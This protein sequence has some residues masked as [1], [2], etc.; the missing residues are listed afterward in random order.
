M[1]RKEEFKKDIEDKDKEIRALDI[2][3]KSAYSKQNEFTEKVLRATE[4]KVQIETDIKSLELQKKRLQ[5]NQNHL[6]KRIDDEKKIF[7]KI[8]YENNNLINNIKE[9]ETQLQTTKKFEEEK[10]KES[11]SL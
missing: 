3:F 6:N 9:I 8:E 11:E 4:S 2:Q 7:K 10:R 1:K 5:E